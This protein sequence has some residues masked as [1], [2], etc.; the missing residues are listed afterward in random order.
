MGIGNC[1]QW[2]RWENFFQPLLEHFD[3]ATAEAGYYGQYTSSVSN[4]RHIVEVNRKNLHET[5]LMELYEGTRLND[6]KRMKMGRITGPLKL[7]NTSKMTHYKS[8][9]VRDNIFTV[10]FILRLR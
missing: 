2:G 6:G 1:S 3:S 8:N 10:F 7:G 5:Q 4:F 9:L